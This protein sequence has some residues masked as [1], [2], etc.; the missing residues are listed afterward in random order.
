LSDYP[1]LNYVRIK[2]I[3][4]AYRKGEEGRNPRTIRYRGITFKPNLSLE[5]VERI[6]SKLRKKR[7]IT[8]SQD[9]ARFIWWKYGDQPQI[10]ID[11]LNNTVFAA[12]D[13]VR[14]SGMRDCQ[15][16]AAI[17]LK[18]LKKGELAKCYSV[19]ATYN[20][21][22]MGGDLG[23]AEITFEAFREIIREYGKHGP[24]TLADL[25][26]KE[27]ERLVRKQKK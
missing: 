11:I 27:R 17:C 13:T 3:E 12:E 9:Q 7:E 5:E 4:Y 8:V 21:C 18:I 19:S 20:P 22:R 25:A 26:Q 6:V 1:Y 2:P 24:K 23:D 10:G 16:Q 15:I 14:Q